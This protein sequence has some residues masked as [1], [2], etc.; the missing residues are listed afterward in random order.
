MTTVRVEI[1][2]SV[3][4][5]A[6]ERSG[7]EA[8]AFRKF[9][10]DKW[11]AGDL[12]PTYRQLED[13]ARTAR[14][15]FGMLL[16]DEPPE[17]E[18]PL[19]DFRTVRDG[20]VGPP[21][22]ELLDTIHAVERR[23]LWFRNH[24]L[25]MGHEPLP[26]VGSLTTDTP[27]VSAAQQIQEALGYDLD[28]RRGGDWTATR[29]RLAELTEQ[30][31]ILV[32]I[33]GY[34]GAATTRTLNPD[35]FRGFSIADDIAPVVFVNGRDTKAAQLFT[36]AHEVAHVW[37]G[38]S[39]IDRPEPGVPDQPEIERWCN[40]VAA[41]VLIP[42]QLLRST[43]DR[44]AQLEDEVS[45][46]ATT[47]RASGLVVLSQLHDIGALSWN[48]YVAARDDERGRALAAL[49]E[50]RADESTGGNWYLN[51]PIIVSRRFLSAVIADTAAGGTAPTEAM[52]LIGSRSRKSLTGLV[53]RYGK[54]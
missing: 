34:A 31:G 37:L 22:A 46:L 10:I 29:T 7:Q 1:Q 23:Q 25:E 3:L 27:I 4:D 52:Q 47:F 49:E 48:D 45:R 28:Q 20:A 18:L 53:Q 21:S 14:T 44:N 2:P 9:D 26:F 17:F 32:M 36:L 42:R 39:G 54:H 11:R 38:K 16:L 51:M 13:F 30:L 35:E 41:E 43:Y 24:L 33:A 40:A 6:I 15:P 5:W 50:S 8:M 12:H 19:P